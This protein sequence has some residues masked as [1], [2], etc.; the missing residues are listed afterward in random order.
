MKAIIPC[1]A[2]L[3]TV[4][5]AAYAGPTGLNTIPTTDIVPQNSW[6]ANLQN[7]NT[8]FGVPAFYSAP[9]LVKQTEFALNGRVEAGVDASYDASR[10]AESFQFNIK[11]TLQNE[12]EFRPNA[13]MGIMNIGNHLIPSYYITLS[14]TLNYDQQQRERYK[15][16]HRRNRKLLGRRV[17][18][19]MMLNFRGALTP[20][21]GAD[22]Q[23]SDSAVFQT[24][25]I[26]GAGNALTAGVAYV[27]PDQ[28][29][30][31]NPALLFSND[32]H[33]LDGFFL[34]I[35]RQFSF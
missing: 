13:A 19:G 20:F 33:R 7:G 23:M 8:G 5:S 9:M 30:V 21:V 10:N 12:N 16:H 25:W 28:K 1:A 14:K 32:K 22:L 15:A 6:I 34:N 27:L 17:H 29:T 11:D 2:L 24:D 35:S 26:S 18:A 3:V 4:A 31:L